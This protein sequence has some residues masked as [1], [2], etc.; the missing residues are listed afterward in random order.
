[1]NIDPRLFGGD[2]QASMNG[3]PNGAAGDPVARAEIAKLRNFIAT[4]VSNDVQML[5]KAIS[6]L[7]GGTEEAFAAVMAEIGEIKR[8]LAA[9][10]GGSV[11]MPGEVVEAANVQPGD[12][13]LPPEY[14]QGEDS[15]SA[16]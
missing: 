13:T 12:E 11:S 16:P 5:T 8:V 1:M 7:N 9:L 2:Y 4:R 14:F 6:D 15:E 3:Q 10:S